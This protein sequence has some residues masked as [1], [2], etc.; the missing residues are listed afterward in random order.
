MSHSASLE[1]LQ[2]TVHTLIYGDPV[3][4]IPKAEW[5]EQVIAAATEVI[6]VM[7]A[8]G[9][10]AREYYEH[11]AGFLESL[12]RH[13]EA[14]PDLVALLKPDC[15]NRIVLRRIAVACER[16]GQLENALEAI[17]ASID[18]GEAGAAE[19]DVRGRVLRSLG[20]VAEAKADEDAVAE[21]NRVEAA[22]WN[23]PNHYYNYK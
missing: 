23:D 11:R 18:T 8:H 20:R 4:S 13:A 16:A 19:R 6:H 10:D 15:H 17:N 7:T 21:Y 12:G 3:L 9:G 1:E 22:K 5:M 14:I 2:K